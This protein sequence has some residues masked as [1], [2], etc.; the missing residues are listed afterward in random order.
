MLGTV[1]LQAEQVLCCN[2]T[3]Y[4][5]VIVQH[6]TP[7]KD[8]VKPMACFSEDIADIACHPPKPPRPWEKD[9]VLPNRGTASMVFSDCTYVVV[10]G[11]PTR[12]VAAPEW[13]L[14]DVSYRTSHESGI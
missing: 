11:L 3:T 13:E 5:T 4:C 6:S 7:P 8:L 1:T 12:D 9:T 10:S 2:L 14:R